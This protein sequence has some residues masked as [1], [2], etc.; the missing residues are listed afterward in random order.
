MDRSYHFSLKYLCYKNFRSK[1]NKIKHTR[2][3]KTKHLNNENE[4]KSHPSSTKISEG[5]F[6]NNTTQVNKNHYKV[7]GRVLLRVLL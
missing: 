6:D 1:Y 7:R 2:Y 5:R 3:P 4:Q